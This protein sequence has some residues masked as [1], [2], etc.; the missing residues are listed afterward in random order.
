MVIVVAGSEEVV[1]EEEGEIVEE[2]VVGLGEEGEEEEG[3]DG[4]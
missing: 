4:R 3:E 1:L 2:A